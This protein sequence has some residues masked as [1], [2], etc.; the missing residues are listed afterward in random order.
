MY[1]IFYFTAES[2]QDS[3]ILE[4]EENIDHNEGN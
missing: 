4:T 2:V 3:E 1:N